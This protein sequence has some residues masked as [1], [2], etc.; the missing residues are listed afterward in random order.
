MQFDCDVVNC[1]EC[2][3]WE[4]STYG[5]SGLVCRTA[6]LM[7]VGPKDASIMVIGEALG[8]EEVVKQEPLVGKQGQLMNH[9]LKMQGLVR[10]NMYITNV[11]KCRPPGNRAPT[12]KEVAV[13]KTK[14][15]LEIEEVKPKII[16]LLGAVAMNTVLG[17]SKG[18]IRLTGKPF[19]NEQ[20]DAVCIPIV[21]PSYVLRNQGDRAND[22]FRKGW[23][24]VYQALEGKGIGK[25]EPCKYVPC[26]DLDKVQTLFKHIEGEKEVSYDIETSGFGW[27]GV[28]KVLCLAFSWKERTGAII[29]FYH[30]NKNYMT[31]GKL[32][33]FWDKSDF[34]FIC[35]MLRDM[36]NEPYGKTMIAQN[37][38]FDNK[39][40]MQANVQ[41]VDFKFDTMLAHHLLQETGAHDLKSLAMEYTDMG[42]YDKGLKKYLLNSKTSYAVIPEEVLWQYAGMDVDATIRLYNIFKQRLIDEG[43]WV[44]FSKIVMPYNK[45][46][47]KMEMRGVRIDQSI[48]QKLIEKYGTELEKLSVGLQELP[49]V[50][51]VEK[52]MTTLA[53]KKSDEVRKTPKEVP[54]VV[55]NPNSVQHKRALLYGDPYSDRSTNKDALE[56]L[57]TKHEGAKYLQRTGTLSKFYGT[58]L[59]NVPE[60][61]HADGRL[62][63]TYKQHGT[64]TGRLSS[65][66]PNL[67]NQP[68]RGEEAQDIRSY[69]VAAEGS[70]LIEA[71]FKQAEFRC[72]AQMSQCPDMIAYIKSG[73]DIHAEMGAFLFKKPE[74]EVTKWDRFVAKM[75]VFGVMYGRGPKSVAEEYDIPVLAATKTIR[76]FLDKFPVGERWLDETKK[77]AVDNGYV[78]NYFG[79]KRRIPVAMG[80]ATSFTGEAGQLMFHS[81]TEIESHALAQAVNSPIQGFAHDCLAIVMIRVGVRL[82][83]EKLKT[84]TLMDIHDAGLWETPDEELKRFV[85]IL[86]EEMERPIAGMN[87]PMRIDISYGKRWSEM[88]DYEDKE[89]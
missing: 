79:R 65:A 69:F 1:K 68:K 73:K 4:G 13:C 50:K 54:P 43:L 51:V 42:Q 22:L 84:S 6:G 37:G 52:L 31:D 38:K 87:I 77:F 82:K 57:S 11:V 47:Q 64:E 19:W 62:H 80:V 83:E 40:L 12:K 70:W 36:F 2:K 88:E 7:G 21:H 35:R 59:K 44:L 14:L 20:Y 55:F 58:Y 30:S 3:L 34:G 72:W 29:P 46:L 67:Q 89:S 56:S 63:T 5:Y 25:P 60:L 41:M 16:V 39:F 10:E 81:S 48:L 24:A 74:E 53:Q 28:D 18:I 17:F 45:L 49:S 26:T 32:E 76:H 23:E 27:S 85:K 71:D 15:Y 33:P 61:I 75:T 86:Y 8:G 66:N 78:V 9:F